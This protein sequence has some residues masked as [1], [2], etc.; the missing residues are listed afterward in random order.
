MSK[1]YPVQPVVPVYGVS[2]DFTQDPIVFSV[3]DDGSRGWPWSVIFVPCNEVNGKAQV[4]L[5]SLIDPQDKRGPLFTTARWMKQKETM[6]PYTLNVARDDWPTHGE[7][8]VLLLLPFQSDGVGSEPQS[9]FSTTATP[10]YWETVALEVNNY[11][12]QT[13]LGSL[14]LGRIEQLKKPPSLP[15]D[16]VAPGGLNRIDAQPDSPKPPTGSLTFA[17]A[18]CQFPS[19]ILDQMPMDLAA[20]PGPADASLLALGKQL[21]AKVPPT[22]ILL[23]G[24]QVY[25][26][27]TAGLFDPK[28]LDEKYRWPYQRRGAS[29]GQLAVRPSLNLTVLGLIDDHEIEDNWDRGAV[30]VPGQEHAIELGKRGY[31]EFQRGLK[32]GATLPADCWRA[33]THEGFSFFLADT[34]T[35]RDTRNTSN[36][37]IRRIMD[38]KQ[39]DAIKIWLKAQAADKP[40]FIAS[41]S[42]LLPRHLSVARDPVT[43]LH[44]DSWDAYPQSLYELLAFICNQ[45]IT[46]LVFLSGDQHIS[47][48]VEATVERIENGK[49]TAKCSFLS[50]HSSALYAPYP[51]ANA[52]PEDFARCETFKFSWKKSEYRCSVESTFAPPGDGF[53]LLS[54]KPPGQSDSTNASHTPAPWQLAVKFH[55]SNGVKT[56]EPKLKV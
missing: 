37:D 16:P 28:V 46:G 27:A 50:V 26:D 15:V 41:S 34:R 55:D 51:F 31:C 36:A 5:D 23:M 38:P 10:E 19:D 44:S 40:K 39:F 17:L 20:T 30:T 52:I 6:T 48:V 45:E 32:H 29:R 42:A 18:S 1:K 14:A 49:V 47:N 3:N 4:V 8:V 11:L 21:S 35:E 24:D 13:S 53:A 22:L 56:N 12:S 9:P 43:A 54:V 33:E 7:F 25:V 2:P